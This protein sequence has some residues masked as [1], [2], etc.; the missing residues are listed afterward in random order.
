MPRFFKSMSV[1][2]A[3]GDAILIEGQDAVH[4]QKSLRL[5]VGEAVLVCDGRSTEYDTVITAFD[6]EGAHLQVTAVRP[7]QA[8]P[9]LKLTLYQGLPK[10]DKL[11]WIIQ[12]AV[13]LGVTQIVPVEMRRSIAKMGDKA[14]KKAKRWQTIADEAASQSGRGILPTVHAPVRFCDILPML[15]GVPSVVCYEGGGEPFTTLI[16]PDQTQLA[17]IIGPEGGIA[18]EEIEA[19]FA[20]GVKAAT[21]G[22]R[23]LRCETAPVAAIAAAMALSGNWT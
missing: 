3:V 21:L 23:I 11:E 17:L 6:G 16:A 12:K 9:T 15:E 18:P 13:E 14:D 22:P 1:P 5:R 19:L 4:L 2:A 7:S 8:E 20:V 10:S